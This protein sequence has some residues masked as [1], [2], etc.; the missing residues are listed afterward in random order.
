MGQGHAVGNAY[1]ERTP[2]AALSQ[3]LLPSCAGQHPHAA[4]VVCQGHPAGKSREVEALPVE[5]N[6]VRVAGIVGVMPRAV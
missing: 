3:A 6:G 5:I 1:G 2:V 4:S